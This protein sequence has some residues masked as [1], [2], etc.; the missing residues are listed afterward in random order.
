MVM[1]MVG[2]CFEYCYN[3][4]CDGKCVLVGAEAAD[5]CPRANKSYKYK[6]IKVQLE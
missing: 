1:Q 2:N 3:R 6:Y 5:I 4:P